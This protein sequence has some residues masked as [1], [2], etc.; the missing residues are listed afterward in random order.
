MIGSRK[1]PIF[2]TTPMSRLTCVSEASR[3]YGVGSTRSTGRLARMSGVP[4]T[5][6]RKRASTAP[7]SPS[8]AAKRAASSGASTRAVSVASRPRDAAAAFFRR[9]G[10]LRL[11]MGSNQMRAGRISSALPLI[12]TST[13]PEAASLVDV[14]LDRERAVPLGLVHQAGGRVDDS[15]GADRE[16][17]VAL[18]RGG[19]GGDV[20][21]VEGLAEPH[22]ARP[23]DGA[24]VR[25]ERRQA[26]LRD[27]RVEPVAAAV[28]AGA[29]AAHVPDRP[30]EPDE[31]LSA[32]F[33][34]QAVDVL[35]HER[36]PGSLARPAREDVVRGVRP[37]VADHLPP[38][39][40]PLPHE[41]RVVLEGFGGRDRLGADFLPEA[42]GAAKRRDARRR[43]HACAGERGDAAGQSEPIGGERERIHARS[44]A[45][46]IISSSRGRGLGPL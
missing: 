37:R 17:D 39:V 26:R 31:A 38:P 43:R 45:R 5:G 14:D 19:C 18:R 16:E 28:R 10:A 22:D 29:P 8:M 42:I 6:S 33:L 4:P 24:A 23:D 11:G 46:R 27:G 32:G 44:L 34:V 9:T 12:A 3:W 35:R 13:R 21:G 41:T 2:S 1:R 7:S 30:V 25:A 40:V 15:R 20:L 36:E